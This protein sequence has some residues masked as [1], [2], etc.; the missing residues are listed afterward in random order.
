[1][2]E[3]VGEQFSAIVFIFRKHDNFSVNSYSNSEGFIF[4]HSSHVMYHSESLS[5][6]GR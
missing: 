4:L 1:M 5:F 6:T 2:D 3:D